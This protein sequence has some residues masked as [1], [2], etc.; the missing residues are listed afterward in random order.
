[1][2]GYKLLTIHKYDGYN[3]LLGKQILSG[4]KKYLLSFSSQRIFF[5]A[6]LESKYIL[7]IIMA[8]NVDRKKWY[9]E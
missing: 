6:S 1:M 2:D 9:M 5:L 4:M 7:S 3:R 8:V